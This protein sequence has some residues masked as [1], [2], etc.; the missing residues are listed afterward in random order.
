MKKAS[1]VRYRILCRLNEQAIQAFRE[2][3]KAD[4]WSIGNLIGRL[5]YQYYQVSGFD[6]A[7]Q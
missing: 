2:G 5:E 7:S 4:A 6:E 3:R 1:F